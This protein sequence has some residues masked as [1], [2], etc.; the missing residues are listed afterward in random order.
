VS[1]LR[2]NGLECF[3]PQAKAFDRC[4]RCT[5]SFATESKLR[6]P[7]GAG[8]SGRVYILPNLHVKSFN[9]EW[10]PAFARF[11]VAS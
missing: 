3:T 5:A 7:A 4:K 9:H 8:L 10:T 1:L 2:F 6:D 11:G